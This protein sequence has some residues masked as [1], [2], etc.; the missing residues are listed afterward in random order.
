MT[1]DPDPAATVLPAAAEPAPSTP[2]SGPLEPETGRAVPP[3]TPGA[4]STVPDRLPDRAPF[5]FYRVLAAEQ[6]T[7]WGYTA[8][9]DEEALARYIRDRADSDENLRADVDAVWRLCRP[10]I[11]QA[12]R[13]RHEE[14][15]R[16]HDAALAWAEKLARAIAA[17]TGVDIG[18]HH[19]SNN[20]WARALEAVKALDPIESGVEAALGQAQEEVRRL[21]GEL[22]WPRLE[23]GPGPAVKAVR[24]PSGGLFRAKDEEGYYWEG[25]G[26]PDV[27]WHTLRQ[28]G[29]LTDATAEIETTSV[30]EGG[31]TG[32]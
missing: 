14:D 9:L 2:P 30:A 6:A 12:R 11:E 4:E 31:G 20:P 28:W 3:A 23:A 1:L 16:L 18:E 24:V 13:E 19:G 22:A 26:W 27:A 29:P 21:T 10:M 15:V 5:G 17:A 32:E 8:T 25:P 7:R